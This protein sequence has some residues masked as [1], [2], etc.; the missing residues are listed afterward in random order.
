MIADPA[1]GRNQHEVEIEGTFGWMKFEIRGIP[2]DENP[3]TGR[4]VAMS[5]VRHLMNRQ[6]RFRIA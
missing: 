5:I 4:I 6:A 3:K 2:S 1:V